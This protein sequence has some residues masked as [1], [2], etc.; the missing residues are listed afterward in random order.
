MTVTGVAMED[1]GRGADVVE[2]AE[3]GVEAL[4]VAAPGGAAGGCSSC[5]GCFGLSSIR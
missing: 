3:T 5:C 2:V 4:P 1:E